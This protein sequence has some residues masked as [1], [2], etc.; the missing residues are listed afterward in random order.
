MA[1]LGHLRRTSSFAEPAAENGLISIDSTVAEERPI[2]AGVFTLG[3]IA[4]D[5]ENFLLA[6]GSFGNNLAKRIGDKRISPELQPR[7]AVLRM[8]F[9]PDSVHH[10]GIHSIR[11]RMAALNRFPC[12]ELPR[13]EL[14]LF[15]RM[16]ADARWIKNDLR[17]AKSSEP[18][19]CWV[20][21]V[22][23]DLH[24]DARVLRIEIRKAQIAGS[25]IK[26]FVIER[27]VRNMHLAVFSKKR[28][29]G[30]Q[31]CAGVVIN[32]GSAALV[33]GDDLRP[34]LRRFLNFLDG[35]F[36]VFLYVRGAFHLH[37]PDGEFVG[38]K[39]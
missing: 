9:K 21:L 16:P 38:H 6:V 3:G 33:H 20:P 36:E 30:I 18:R 22:P 25:E 24:A 5:D 2:A 23:A 32:A 34:A 29:V 28:S 39:I 31:N 17:A 12:F 13:A 10:R 19:A 4:F 8:S 26:F 37:E 15:V 14:F 27:V 7:I 35:A 11:D 1:T